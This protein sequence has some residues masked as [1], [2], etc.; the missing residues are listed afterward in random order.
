[1][2]TQSWQ[3]AETQ[4]K[5][6][7]RI[8]APRGILS[9]KNAII[10][11]GNIQK[12]KALVFGVLQHYCHQHGSLPVSGTGELPLPPTPGSVGG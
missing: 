4:A 10:N 2:K 1:M 5:R 9:P 12:R 8:L 7:Q 3:V 11:T 6:N